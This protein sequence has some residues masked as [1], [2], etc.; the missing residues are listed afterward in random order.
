MKLKKEVQLTPDF[1]NVQY[2]A[3]L[4]VYA[5]YSYVEKRADTYTF[6]LFR[7]NQLLC[8]IIMGVIFVVFAFVI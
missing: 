5:E 6:D 2:P 8:Y 4:T 7:D 3:S 1:S